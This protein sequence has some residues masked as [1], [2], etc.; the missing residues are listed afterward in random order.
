MNDSRHDGSLSDIPLP[1][2][3]LE[4][5]KEAHEVLEHPGLAARLTELVGMPVERGL[6]M[7]PTAASESINAATM[8]ALTKAL[9]LAVSTLGD[10]TDAGPRLWSHKLM[11]GVSGAA[12]GAFGLPALAIELPLSTV[13]ILRSVADIA[14]SHGEELSELEV[15]LACLEVFALGGGRKTSEE[16]SGEDEGT[17]IG[18]LAVRAGLAKHVSDAAKHL[19]RK[20]LTEP[21]APPLVRFIA[22][23]AKRFGV[24]VSEKVAAQAVPIIG[25]AGGAL[26]NTFFIDHYQDI[27]RAHFTMRALEREHGTELVRRIYRNL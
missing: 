15:R 21:T 8:K 7:L 6:Q 20:G 16:G 25:A 26:L 19:A 2:E 3:H 18:Y 27:A 13:L 10:K 1:P 11:A 22:V 4:A 17:E 14:R 5:I 9:D 24:V 23:I 12:G